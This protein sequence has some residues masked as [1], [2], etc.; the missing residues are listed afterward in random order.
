MRFR[1]RTTG[2]IYSLFE[3]QQKFSHVSF[4][5]EWTTDTY[6]FAN[7]DPVITIHEPPVSM[8]NRAEYAGVQLIDGAWT[9]V[10]NEVPKY[11]DPTEQ[12]EWVVLCTETKWDEIR[13]YRNLLLSQTDYTQFADTPITPTSKST[14]ITYRQQLRDIT[15]QSDPYNIIWPTPPIYEKE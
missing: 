8:L 5:N 13:S 10:W 15:T 4:A 6:D 2:Q 12:A 7:V 9:D 14:F 11:D 1:D 3:L